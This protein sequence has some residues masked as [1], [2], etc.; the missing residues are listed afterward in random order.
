[1]NINEYFND[2]SHLTQCNECPQILCFDFDLI[3]NIMVLL[4]N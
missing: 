3:N 2:I 4:R 1:M